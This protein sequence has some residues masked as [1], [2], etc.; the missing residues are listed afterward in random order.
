MHSWR[1]FAPAPGVGLL[2]L[3]L[4]TLPCVAQAASSPGADAAV[5][6]TGTLPGVQAIGTV[7]RVTAADIARRGARTLDEAIALLPGVNIRTGGNGTPRV[8][9]RGLVTR[10]VK[11]L[12]NGVPLNSTYDGQF[13]PTTIPME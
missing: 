4:A 11:L 9:L 10:H 1:P 5:V 13:D 6:V 3:V 8:D 7:R 12:I 2:G